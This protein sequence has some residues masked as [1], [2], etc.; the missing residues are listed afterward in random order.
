MTPLP[1]PRRTCGPRRRPRAQGAH[2]RTAAGRDPAGHPGPRRG[3]ALGCRGP[4]AHRRRSEAGWPG[5]AVGLSLT[6]DGARVAVRLQRAADR[7][8]LPD[9]GRAAAAEVEVRV[10]GAVR[11]SSSPSQL[12]RRVRPLRPGLS[13]APPTVTAGTLGGFV[14][15]REGLAI[16]SNN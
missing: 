14:R 10:I 16:L 6:G 7:A 4:D 13:V 9:L 1:C 5:V 11:P 12:Q 2:H 8:L 15:T 3:V